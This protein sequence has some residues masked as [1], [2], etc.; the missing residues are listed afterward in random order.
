MKC[1]V[2]WLTIKQRMADNGWMYSGHVSATERTDEWAWKTNLL[3][4]E[5]VR[6][7]KAGVRPQTTVPLHSLQEASSSGKG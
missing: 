5:L 2:V 4:K 1:V 6:G 3:V 7:S